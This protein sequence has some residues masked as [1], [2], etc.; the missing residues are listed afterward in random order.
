MRGG[1]L[2]FDVALSVLA[3]VI[4][5]LYRWVEAFSRPFGLLDLANVIC[6]ILFLVY[7][8]RRQSQA[9]LTAGIILCLW[10]LLEMMVI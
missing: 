8:L 9:A 4:A 1:L 10:V 7:G 6:G 3:V 2:A 5:F